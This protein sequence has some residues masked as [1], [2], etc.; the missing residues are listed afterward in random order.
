MNVQNKLTCI[1]LLGSQ[2]YLNHCAVLFAKQIFNVIAIINPDNDKFDED[3]LYELK[4]DYV[5]SFLNQRILYGALLK[6]TNVN[7]HPSPPNWP[8]RGGASLAIYTGDKYFGATA[9]T[10]ELK[11]DAGTILKTKYFTILP[12]EAC[13]SV[14]SR[15]ENA[16]LELFYE[17][18]SYIALHKKLPEPSGETWTRSATSRKQ[19]E[20][21]L[22]LNPAD[23]DDFL[24]KIK[25]SKHSKLPGPYVIVHGHKFGLVGKD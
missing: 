23:K 10:M 12:D 24:L 6:C 3:E 15:S 11:V 19:F 16:C 17:I 7:F 22:L 8:G 18:L 13:E 20:E 5:F 14:F 25:A 4:P 9:H 1:I 2:N 21:W